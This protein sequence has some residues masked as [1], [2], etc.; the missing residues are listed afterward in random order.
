MKLIVA[1]KEGL[2]ERGNRSDRRQK[3][4]DRKPETGSRR[5]KAG[6]RY[7]E[8]ANAAPVANGTRWALRLSVSAASETLNA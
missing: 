4:G 5:Q 1:Y 3:A 8:V 6:T 2:N 7:P